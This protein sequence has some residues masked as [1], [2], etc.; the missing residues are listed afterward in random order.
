MNFFDIVLGSLILIGLIR[1][2]MKGFFIEIA[3]LVALIAGIYG[4]IHFSYIIGNYLHQKMSWQEHY[5][6]LAAFAITFILVIV[7]VSLLGKS[8]TKIANFAMLGIVNKLAGAVFGGLKIAVILGVI[9]V[10]FNKTNNTFSFLKKETLKESILFE[11]VK[12]IGIF[13]FNKVLKETSKNE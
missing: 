13:V 3:S 10:F 12:N 4:A 11:P 8:L 7:I 1:G 5:I 2:F 9:L 6:N